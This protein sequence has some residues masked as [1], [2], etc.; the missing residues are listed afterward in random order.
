[1]ELAWK[2]LKAI[3]H[4]LTLSFWTAIY[5]ELI[6]IESQFSDMQYHVESEMGLRDIWAFPVLSSLKLW[7]GLQSV[8]C[9]FYILNLVLWSLSIKRCWV[10]LTPCLAYSLY[11]NYI[12][13][14]SWFRKL[15]IWNN[16]LNEFSSPE[17]EHMQVIPVTN[18]RTH[19]QKREQK[20]AIFTSPY[21]PFKI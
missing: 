13:K 6:R 20:P 12:F 9:M 1:M 11:K 16:S 17:F 5:I 15:F 4:Q 3:C 14:V 21:F 19:R 10:F 8:Y 2:Y 18:W 7:Y